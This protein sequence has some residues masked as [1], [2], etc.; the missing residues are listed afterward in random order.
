MTQS[1]RGVTY[2]ATAIDP[3]GAPLTKPAES[4][5]ADIHG[6]VQVPP[7]TVAGSVPVGSRLPVQLT[8]TPHGPAWQVVEG[9]PNQGAFVPYHHPSWSVNPPS[10]APIVPGQGMPP[11]PPGY[12]NPGVVPPRK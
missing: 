5:N 1:Q 10:S 6:V 12:A 7:M 8:T 11:A 2:V 4:R 3:Q 9:N